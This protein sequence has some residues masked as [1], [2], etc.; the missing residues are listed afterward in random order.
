MVVRAAEPARASPASKVDFVW[1][2]PADQQD[3]G[4]TFSGQRRRQLQQLLKFSRSAGGRRNPLRCL[5]QEEEEVAA[6]RLLDLQATDGTPLQCLLQEENVAAARLLDLQARDGPPCGACCRRW[7]L[8]G[9]SAD[10]NKRWKGSG[11]SFFK[12][13]PFSVVLR[14]QLTWSS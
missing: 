8:W 4:V 13:R 7:L 1:L 5:L 9:S 10:E 6:V 3:T 2:L 12:I 11:C 14:L